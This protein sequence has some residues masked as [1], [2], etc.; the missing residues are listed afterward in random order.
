MSVRNLLKGL[1]PQKLRDLILRPQLLLREP[2]QVFTRTYQTNRWNGRESRSGTGSDL[3]ETKNLINILPAV[4]DQLR[5]ESLLD[6]PC[7]DFNWMS[8]VNM[9]GKNYIGADIVDDL[10]AVN[11]RDFAS[12]SRQFK[13]L[14]LTSDTLPK[15]DLVFCRDCLVHLSNSLV[16]KAIENVKRSESTYFMVT[17][18][19]NVE[20]NND[21]VTGSWRPINLQAEPFSFAEPVFVVDEGYSQ[22]TGDDKL[23]K[24]LCVWKVSD[25][26]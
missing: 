3:A 13:V 21:I 1:L 14:D 24:H 6:I 12:S 16:K 19:P 8:R 5:V 15:V 17:T 18:F 4:F 10:I 23:T 25:I 7:G 26:K 11:Q 22:L 9:N 2:K 20:K